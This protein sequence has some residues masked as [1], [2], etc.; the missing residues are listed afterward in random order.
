MT[1]KIGFAQT[2]CFLWRVIYPKGISDLELGLWKA[3]CRIQGG[4]GSYSYLYPF[5]IPSSSEQGSIRFSK[6]K[7]QQP[8]PLQNNFI[9]EPNIVGLC[10]IFIKHLLMGQ[11]PL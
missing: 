5:I 2:A 10:L 4:I 7:L 9:K 3:M 11:A 8:A 1:L 6:Q